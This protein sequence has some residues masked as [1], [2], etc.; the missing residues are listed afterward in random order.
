MSLSAAV[1]R[2]MQEM[3]LT[4]EQAIELAE[5]W[6]EGAAKQVPQLT[7]G[8][9]RTRKWR[10]KQEEKRHRDVTVTSPRDETP[11]TKVSPTPPS[12]TQPP[13]PPYN[14]P[15]AQFD[16]FWAAY[17]N[18]TAKRAARTAFERA[19]K[20]ISHTDP[21]SLLLSAIERA[22]R[23][24]KWREGFVPNPATWLNGDCWEDGIEEARGR[25][26]PKSGPVDPA[27]QANRIQH[28]RD[29]GEWRPTWGP[30]PDEIA[31]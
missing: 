24:R 12:K 15:L 21:V 5:M 7:P 27:V 1:L 18:K 31:A 22:K 20:R 9:V 19:L 23:S 26:P 16:A 13:F 3:G 14:P 25:D 2:K 4:L 8:A 30:R 29:T 11:E 10:E 6:E 28:F 17:P